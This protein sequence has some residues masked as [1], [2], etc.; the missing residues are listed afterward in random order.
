M[1]DNMESKVCSKCNIDLD[2]S[3]FTKSSRNKTGYEN[4]CKK[5]RNVG[6]RKNRA[7]LRESQNFKYIEGKIC[8][9][10]REYKNRNDYYVSRNCTDGL[11]SICKKCANSR[12]NEY[13][14]N[15]RKTDLMF[16]LSATIRSYL[17]KSL[18]AGNCTKNSFTESYLGRSVESFKQY[19]SLWFEDDWN[20][21]NYGKVWEIDHIIPVS[22]IKCDDDARVI[23]HFTNM[24]ATSIAENRL[25]SGK[26]LDNGINEMI[27][28]MQDAMLE[29][30]EFNLTNSLTI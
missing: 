28:S 26:L 4:S 21:D 3:N 9:D 29:L 18:K 1:V 16:R 5:C 25:K 7:N 13:S 2:I 11:R 14:K 30:A 19:I 22:A 8:G 24:R 27:I 23:W 12:H 15:R 10:C 17:H 20:W 6:R